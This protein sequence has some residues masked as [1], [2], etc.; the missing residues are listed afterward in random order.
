MGANK[1]KN[2]KKA[3]NGLVHAY[4]GDY[5]F[6]KTQLKSEKTNCPKPPLPHDPFFVKR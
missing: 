6:L 1:K 4:N 2:V 5:F 3:D